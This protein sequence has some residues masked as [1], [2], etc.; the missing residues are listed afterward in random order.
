VVKAAVVD[1]LGTT[2]KYDDF[3]EPTPRDGNVVATVEAASLKNIDRGLISGNHYGSASLRPPLVAGID[4][5]ARLDGGRRVYTGAVAP[6]GMMAERTLIYPDRAVDVPAGMDSALAAAI[7]NP[8]VSAWFS[9][10]YAAKIR[11]G[12][13]VLI[14]GATGV[15]GAVAVQLAKSQFGAGRVVV[16]G[17]NT[18]R[19]DWL[20]NV[21]ADAA[22]TIGADDLTGTV[23]AEHRSHPIDVVIDYLWGAPAQS[24]LA[25]LGN[26]DLTTE[27]HATRYVQV[28][29]M[30]GPT[31]ELPAAVLRSAG[32]ELLGTGIGS[33]PADAQQRV[34]TEI[35]PRLFAL[36]ASGD[37][38]LTVEPHDLAEVESV[39]N[40]AAPSGSRVVLVP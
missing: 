23:A 32:V 35:L 1:Q 30:A 28:G 34:P 7:P 19:L 27:C 31:I 5:I 9:L 12:Q 16:A 26:S 33:V 21:G 14:L 36:A 3:D 29:S 15:T 18:D 11:P 13:N 6:F 2:P 17:R 20:C 8:G 10:E 37:L 40:A 39:W 25:A 22:I 24:V 38:Q 4:G